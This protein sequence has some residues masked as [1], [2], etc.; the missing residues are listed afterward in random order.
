[1]AA[2]AC[3]IHVAINPKYIAFSTGNI[4]SGAETH[5]AIPPLDTPQGEFVFARENL[6]VA[7]AVTSRPI[8][9]SYYGIVTGLLWSL[10]SHLLFQ[11]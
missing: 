5:F 4:S 8:P 7:L 9:T 6:E 11:V 1:M 3:G 2:C 10:F